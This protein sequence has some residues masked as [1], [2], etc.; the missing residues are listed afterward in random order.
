VH[1][2]SLSNVTRGILERV[3]FAKQREGGLGPPLF[4]VAGAVPRLNRFRQEV[5][6]FVPSSTPPDAH[7]DYPMRY[8]G[9][10][11]TIYENAVDSLKV[12][13][14]RRQD[15]FLRTFVK[16][17]KINFTSKPDPAPR[18]IQPR[19]PRY[20]VILGKHIKVVEKLLYKGVARVFNSITICKGLNASARGKVIS[21]KWSRFK[22]P[23]GIGLDASRFDQHCSKPILEWEHGFYKALFP[24]SRELQRVLDWQIHNN[25]TAHTPDGELKYR[26]T[27]CRMSGDMNTALGNCLI[28]CGLV[29]TYLRE[30]GIRKYELMNDGDDCVLIMERRHLHRLNNLGNWFA[31][32]GYNMTREP[33]VYQLEELEFC[34]C[35]PVFDGAKWTMVRDPRVSLAKDLITFK[36]LNTRGDFDYLR[37]AISDCGLSLVGGMPIVQS[38]YLAL[39][40]GAKRKNWKR[41]AN[42]TTGMQFMAHNM[43]RKISDPTPEARLSFYLAFGY[44]PERS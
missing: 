15:S 37:C 1:N 30:I 41:P 17:E 24:Q 7:E 4:P 44:T 26:V 31:D 27:G 42:Y 38:Y 12:L 11:R 36:S 21:D 32:F 22:R 40:R 14:L 20:N 43:N 34:Q 28:M 8:R 23:V 25:G 9:R 10:K 13:P 18:V 5:L 29:W 19:T 35:R 39:Q 2:S 6:R 33:P 16:A 3:Y